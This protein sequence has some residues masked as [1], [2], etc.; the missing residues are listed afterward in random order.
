LDEE[1]AA[2]VAAPVPDTP[3]EV[4]DAKGDAAVVDEA[5]ADDDADDDE[6]D[7]VVVGW[8]ELDCELLLTLGLGL[9]IG[10]EPGGGP[11]G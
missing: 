4:V 5:G 1:D 8:A 10:M 11:P 9:R 2:A 7:A 3:V 6:G